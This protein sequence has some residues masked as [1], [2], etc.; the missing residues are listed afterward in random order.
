MGGNTVRVTASLEDSQVDLLSEIEPMDRLLGLTRALKEGGKVVVKRAKQLCPKP[1]Y[2]GDDP[3]KKPLQETIG[4][5]V[6]KYDHSI[7]IVMGPEYPA[8]AHG[9]L[10][11]FGHN[12]FLFGVATG[13]FLPAQPFMRPAADETKEEQDSAI[14][15]SLESSIAKA[16]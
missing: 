6:R 8:G 12:H 5:E 13:N 10:I 9:H 7:V 4:I 11:E 14:T 1:G 2:P 3:T 15:S 16:G